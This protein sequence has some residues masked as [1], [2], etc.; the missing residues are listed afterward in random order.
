MEAMASGLPVVA[1]N[2]PAVRGP[3]TPEATGPL[4]PPPDPAA[5]A[6]AIGRLLAD[7]A[8]CARLGAAGVAHVRP[9]Y[10]SGGLT[11]RVTAIYGEVAQGARD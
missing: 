11:G 3:I 6:S 7:P 5:L 9:R 4:V 10:T 8:L 2:L 1:S